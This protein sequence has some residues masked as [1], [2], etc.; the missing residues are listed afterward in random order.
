[1]TLTK[2]RL[3]GTAPITNTGSIVASPSA[4]KIVAHHLGPGGHTDS[5]LRLRAQFQMGVIVD[6][7]DIPPAGWWIGVSVT[8]LAFW[9]ETSTLVIPNATGNSEHYLGS[10]VMAPTLTD[11]SFAGGGYS[12]QWRLDD[13]LVT[14]TSR[15]VSTPS[16]GPCVNLGIVVYDTLGALDGTYAD[17][18]I[19]LEPRLFT[20]WGTPL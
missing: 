10:K 9:S 15:A 8:L 17:I 18:N 12:V 16:T 5:F 2:H 1:M 13:D 11:L 20:L 3:Y 14:E 4:P 6:G 7:S 19:C